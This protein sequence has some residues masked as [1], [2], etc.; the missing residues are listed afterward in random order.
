MSQ[1]NASLFFGVESIIES[2]RI[3]LGKNFTNIDLDYHLEMAKKYKINVVLLFI[4]AYH[5]ET[6]EDFETVKNW[7][8]DRKHYANDP[9]RNVS[10][11]TL[12]IMPYT[13]LGR[14]LEHHG[15]VTT[16]NNWVSLKTGVS[17]Q[18]R[19]NYINDLKKVI[20]EECGFSC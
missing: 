1:T 19:N 12:S 8:R 2:V 16:K 15:I 18:Q 11:S 14:N 4:A 13:R 3:N 5:S 7:F 9:I 17:I 20:I 6:M 10:I